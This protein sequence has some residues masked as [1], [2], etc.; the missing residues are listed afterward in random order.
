[1]SVF[2]ETLKMLR[3]RR[4]IGQRELAELL[5]VSPDHIKRLETD[6]ATPD[7]KLLSAIAAIFEVTPSYLLGTVSRECVMGEP[8]YGD[9]SKKYVSV[10]V[11]SAKLITSTICRE[12]DIIE[13]VVVPI[14]DNS[15]ESYIAVLVEE[16]CGIER[17][18]KGDI[19]IIK[20]TTQLADGDI[21]AV[22]IKDTYVTFMR[23][24]RNGQLI[25]LYCDN[26]GK[27]ITYKSG[28]PGYNILGRVIG[29]QAKF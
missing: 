9:V 14:P 27:E 20:K 25:N 10:P 29:V 19:A 15:Y 4:N 22:R 1:M 18:M 5:S 13:R 6:Y 24:K 17:F 7:D 28:E 21:V 26:T 11:V 23:Y 8:G 3:N 2:S 16:D 12:S